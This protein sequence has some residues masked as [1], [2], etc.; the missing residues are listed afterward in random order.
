MFWFKSTQ[1]MKCLPPYHDVLHSTLFSTQAKRLLA[2]SPKHKIT[3]DLAEYFDGY[4]AAGKVEAEPNFL[5]VR[6]TG[7]IKFFA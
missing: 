1:N 5:Q 2:W 7:G 3:D 4:K 6:A